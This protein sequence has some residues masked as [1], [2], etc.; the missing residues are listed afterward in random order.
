MISMFQHIDIFYS[1]FTLENS[2]A[3]LFNE[4][5]NF[6]QHFQQ[7]QNQYSKSNML[8]WLSTCL[9]KFAFEWFNDQSKFI[10]LH[11]FDIVL[12]T[13]FFFKQNNSSFLSILVSKSTCEI[14]KSSTKF[15]LIALSASSI[16]FAFF[17]L[18]DSKLTQ[19]DS[20]FELFCEVT[21]IL[22]QFSQFHHQH[23]KSDLLDLLHDCLWNFVLNWFENQLKFTSLHDFDITLTKAFSSKSF[24][25]QKQ[26][27]QQKS[28]ALKIAKKIKFNA[29]KNIKRIKSKALKAKEIAKSTSTFQNIDIFHSILTCENR[30]LSEFAK[31]LQ[32]FQQCQHLYRKSNLL[33]LLL[34]CLWSFAF[35]IWFDKQTIM[36]LTLLNE[37]IEILRV[38]FVDVSFA[39]LINCS[40]IICMRC[41]KSFNFKNKL[42]NHVRNQHAKKSINNSNFMINT[43]KSTC[44]V[45]EKS[46]VIC[47]LNSSVS[48]KSFVFFATSRK[49]VSKFEIAFE[50]IISS[51]S[52]IL[53]IATINNALQLMKNES[54][55]CF[56]AS[57]ISFSTLE[58]KNQKIL[59]RKF[60]TFS[61]IFESAS[62]FE[63]IIS[64]ECL[65]FSFL[66]FEYISKSTKNAFIQRLFDSLI[67]QEF[68]IFIATSKQI[69]ESTMIF[70]IITSS[71]NSS[72]SFNASKIVSKSMKN[73][74]IQSF[75]IDAFLS[76]DTVKSI[77][78]IEKK[79]TIIETFALQISH[80]SFTISRSQLV[81]EII[82]S[83]N[84]NLSIETFKVISKSMKSASN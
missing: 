15:A 83:K 62:I 4:V 11:E 78:E 32:H 37:W 75:I 7:C 43:V 58:S 81:F 77:C 60:A 82:S 1:K 72:L 19:N 48:Q 73:I 30:Q 47:L 63:S 26:Q 12:T 59:V 41:E 70:E 27:E 8:E 23:R 40:K 5:E 31:F 76:N 51:T 2:N 67:S 80:I 16:S 55:Q 74:S 21:D 35:D 18:F 52:S 13:A 65:N 54:I 6:L 71:K 79:S 61:Q 49:H 29:I 68:E 45:V 22:R 38:D 9:E 84:S 64:S 3:K 50:T 28:N 57:W 66:T 25:S 69:F 24:A 44:E 36:K 39:K 17:D 53:S 10:F 42:R 33:M 46:T 56:S 14:L 20:E 34:T